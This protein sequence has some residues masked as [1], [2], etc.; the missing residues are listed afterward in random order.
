MLY[1][2]ECNLYPIVLTNEFI[3]YKMRRFLVNPI[4]VAAGSQAWVCVS[5]HAGIAGS[6]P[7]GSMDVCLL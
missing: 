7:A 4:P 1:E 3:Q 6:N 5:S 2:S